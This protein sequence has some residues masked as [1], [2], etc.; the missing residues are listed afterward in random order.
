MQ[1]G[2]YQPNENLDGVY[3]AN[4]VN[5][6]N[7]N[8]NSIVSFFRVPFDSSY[9]HIQAYDNFSQVNTYL[10]GLDNYF[11]YVTDNISYIQPNAPRIVVPHPINRMLGSN[12]LRV[13]SPQ[14]S[15]MHSNSL[16]GRY[17]VD[18]MYY[19]I[20]GVNYLAPNSTEI[21]LI[22]DVYTTFMSGNR[23][24]IKWGF[25]ERGHLPMRLSANWLTT[26]SVMQ[27]YLTEPE[28]LTLGDTYQTLQSTGGTLSLGT[29]SWVVISSTSDIYP[30]LNP[31]VP[32]SV[33]NSIR[34]T[35]GVY[36]IRMSEFPTFTTLINTSPERIA[37][38]RNIQRIFV[39]PSAFISY[40]Y[41][42]VGGWGSVNIYR[43]FTVSAGIYANFD[44]N[45]LF[46]SAVYN[47]WDSEN[48][49]SIGAGKLATA[50]YT[51]IDIEA[52]YGGRL[53]IPLQ[54]I[55]FS[56]LTLYAHFDMVGDN[57]EMHINLNYRDGT[58]I[59]SWTRSSN[60][61]Y[62]AYYGNDFYATASIYNDP[63]NIAMLSDNATYLLASNRA[64]ISAIQENALA[65]QQLA[66]AQANNNYSQSINSINAGYSNAMT[67]AVASRTAN[68]ISGWSAQRDY[69]NQM[70]TNSLQNNL[71]QQLLNRTSTYGGVNAVLSGIAGGG[72]IVGAIAGG[73]SGGINAGLNYDIANTKLNQQYLINNMSMYNSHNT[74]MAAINSMG[75]NN[76]N[77]AVQIAQTS[78]Q[79]AV[80]NANLQRQMATESASANY[81]AIQRS[82]KAEMETYKQA[83]PSMIGA[84]GGGIRAMNWLPVIKASLRTVNQRTQKRLIEYWLKYGYA[85]N[86]IVTAEPDTQTNTPIIPIS[87]YTHRPTYWKFNEIEF[88][89][90]GDDST[91][92]RQYPEEIYQSLKTI[93]QNGTSVWR[94]VSQTENINNISKLGE[95][96]GG[97]QVDSINAPQTTE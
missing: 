97:L 49:T 95:Y 7:W 26:P 45:Q 35:I 91:K 2:I 1:D 90:L 15:Q 14:N 46:S 21:I 20:V 83:A 18:Y 53:T 32:I 62:S 89:F 80:T 36:L 50:P 60:I 28:G 59:N 6:P 73:I 40:V 69:R 23:I 22:L 24:G 57:I 16:G 33:I 74:N 87:Q 64:R 37:V 44:K 94:Y 76:Y 19:F 48:A 65:S 39:I 31:Q 5:Y 51:Y 75:A 41:S 3:N 27:E 10:D 92:S 81:A 71:D 11:R 34:Q 82:I 86:R 78:K 30:S 4:T 96:I 29:D 85:Y 56:T 55:Y 68:E 79:A 58:G 66:I 43:E 70:T 84:F 8:V 52:W 63:P 72:S 12:Y 77:S 47:G 88:S 42:P 9:R 54:S 13:Y 38:I 67:S 61:G 93:F 17:N 25:L